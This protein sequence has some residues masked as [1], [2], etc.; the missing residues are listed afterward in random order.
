M[1]LTHRA[2]RDAEQGTHAKR[3]HL[4]P[5]QHAD[6][7]AGA[8]KPLS[9]PLNEA[10]RVDHV[11]RFS[12][13]LTGE[14]DALGQ[15]RLDCP[16]GFGA[17][18]R[19]GNAQGLEAGL[20][21]VSQL[22]AVDVIAPGPQP[23]TQQD[24]GNIGARQLGAGEI[25]RQ[26]A[27]PR[28]Q[29]LGRERRAG[30]LQRGTAVLGLGIAGP[31]Q[32]EADNRPFAGNKAFMRLPGLASETRRAGA[33]DQHRI[34]IGRQGILIDNAG[35]GRDCSGERAGDEFDLHD[36]SGKTGLAVRRCPQPDDLG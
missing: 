27:L 13:Q 7:H 36:C 24:G 34:E 5:A 26:G 10:G 2:L 16:G 14:L 28:S 1:R 22:G 32:C 3:G 35:D 30:A 15:R 19:R 31:G 6:L 18:R 25:E 9:R 4:I 17:F 20:V 29:E 12:H 33:F 11:G 21:I 8:F 23:G